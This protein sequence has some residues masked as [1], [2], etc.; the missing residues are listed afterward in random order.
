MKIWETSTRISPPVAEALLLIQV[1]GQLDSAQP[2]FEMR[3]APVSA[4]GQDPLDFNSRYNSGVKLCQWI[5]VNNI[6]GPVI[7]TD[8]T[9]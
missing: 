8:I 6:P 1:L 4:D 3:T 9:P 7:S 2:D 5:I